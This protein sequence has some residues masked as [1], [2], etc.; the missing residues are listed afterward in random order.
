MSTDLRAAGRIR[1]LLGGV[2]V[3][4]G[5]RSTNLLWVL[6]FAL[7]PLVVHDALLAPLVA[8]LGWFAARHLAP[9]LRA[10]L[11]VALVVGGSLLLVGLPLVIVQLTG[12]RPTDNP[13]VDPLDYSRN[14]IA[15][16]AVVVLTAAAGTGARVAQRRRATNARPPSDQASSTS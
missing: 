15:L 8:L 10:P 7:G 2:L 14:M 5:G 4:T 11:Q 3:L 9:A 1:V 12:R 13:S 6:V 16:L